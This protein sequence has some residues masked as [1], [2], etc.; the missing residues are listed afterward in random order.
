MAVAESGPTPERRTTVDA[1]LADAVEVRLAKI[2][3]W[4]TVACFGLAPLSILALWPLVVLLAGKTTAVDVN[5]AFAFSFTVSVAWA[6]TETARRRTTQENRRL[7]Q[8]NGGLE[9][10]LTLAQQEREQQSARIDRLQDDLA[11]ARTDSE[12]LR[13]ELSS[14]HARS[15]DETH[16][17]EG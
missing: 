4:K 12:R 6:V 10:Q 13:S 3:A 15:I 16:R 7:K 11:Q 5:I 9:G 17:G 1:D 2:N 8:R 14:R